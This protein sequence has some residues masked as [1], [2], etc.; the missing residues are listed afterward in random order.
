MRSAS[1]LLPGDGEL[2]LSAPHLSSSTFVLVSVTSWLK[3]T[4]NINEYAAFG[5]RACAEE[6]IEDSSLILMPAKGA[7]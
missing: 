6:L 4:H 3:N 7:G 5:K 1:L 2:A